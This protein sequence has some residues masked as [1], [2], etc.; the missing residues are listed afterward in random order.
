MPGLRPTYPLET[1][2]LRLRPHAPEDLDD[3]L[4]FHSDPEVVRFIPWPVRDRA[5]TQE[6]LAANLPRGTIEAPG[7][8]LVLAVELRETGRV[9]GEVLLKWVS[10]EDREG[11]LGFA[12]ARGHHGRGYAAEAARAMLRLGFQELGLR[13]IT[14]VCIEGNEA[15]ARLLRRLGFSQESRSDVVFK[16]VR[17]AQL[18]FARTADE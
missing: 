10:A 3:L 1:E 14:A 16:D 18:V 5:A 13:R 12:F 8:W 17:V 6:A 7:Q 11:E 15:S 4:V 9:I 2:R